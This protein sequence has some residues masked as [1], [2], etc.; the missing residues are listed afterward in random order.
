MTDHLVVPDERVGIELDE[1]LSL[2]YPLVN[3]GF[4]RKEVHAG[5]VLLDGN[6]T[7]PSKRLRRNQVVTIEFEDVDLPEAPVAPEIPVPILFEDEATLVVDK[8]YG[9]AV[10]PER[11]RRDAAC[12]SGALLAMA[13]ERSGKVDPEGPPDEGGL[14]FRPRLVHRIDKDTSGAVLVAKHIE[15]ERALRNAFEG[16][17]VHKEY[18]ALAEGDYETRR[19]DEPDTIDLPI[20]PDERKT[21][22]MCVREKGGRASQTLV[23]IEERFRGFTLLRCRPLTGRTHQIRV[24]LAELGFPLAV[25]PT[26]GH[27][28]SLMLSELKR[29]YK[30]KPGRTESPLIDRLTLHA[31]ALEFP[32][33]AGDDSESATVRVESPLPNDFVRVLKQLRKVRRPL[34]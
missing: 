32:R 23:T 3:K 29:G 5:N 21:G 17:G 13:I 1:F 28:T 20:A 33:L 24:H 10:E 6:A 19:D 34:Q 14:E 27:R 25:D 11:W 7:H 4:L 2:V 8:P 9:L 26:Y 16:G 18:L 30:P 22:R 12:L 31:Q 15:A